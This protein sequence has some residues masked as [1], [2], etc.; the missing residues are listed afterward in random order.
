M[1]DTVH[2]MAWRARG[3]AVVCGVD[4]VG[5]GPLA[6]PVV[7]AAVIVPDDAAVRCH[8]LAEAGDSKA[9]TA[10]KRER[11]AAYIHAHCTVVLAEASVAEIDSLNIRGATLLAMTRA[12]SGLGGPVALVDGL[13]V[14]AGVQGQAVVK[15]DAVELCIACASI[16]AKVHR[17]A[18]MAELDKAYPGYG[19]ASNAGYGSATHMAALQTLGPTPH[20]RASFAPVAA[21]LEARAKVAA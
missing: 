10:K 11:M 18:V 6:G 20:H 2:E 9:L 14:P 4:E 15:G 7:T 19:W 3:C 12:V 16:V 21:A 5:R 13:D 8:L 17:D 1:L